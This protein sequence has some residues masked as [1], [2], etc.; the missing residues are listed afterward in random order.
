[1]AERSLI[2]PRLRRSDVHIDT[3][4]YINM[5]FKIRSNCWL[6]PQSR[7]IVCLSA[8]QVT[9]FTFSC[10]QQ[11]SYLESIAGVLETIWW[12]QNRCSNFFYINTWHLITKLNRFVGYVLF[13]IIQFFR[14]GYHLK[15]SRICWNLN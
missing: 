13:V 15:A 10:G 11:S 14:Y 1:M 5:N 2:S 8:V 12:H 4:V 6:V 7:K 9:W 3:G